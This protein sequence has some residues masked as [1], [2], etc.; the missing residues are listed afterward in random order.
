MIRIE[1]TPCCLCPAVVELSIT[2]A[3]V[4][5]DTGHLVLHLDCKNCNHITV[6]KIPLIGTGLF[7]KLVEEVI[8]EAA[9]SENKEIKQEEKH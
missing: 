3:V 8:K 9:E 1:R 2:I 7:E 5:E 6:M 4:K